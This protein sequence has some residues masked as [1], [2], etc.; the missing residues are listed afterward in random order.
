MKSK[1][2]Q[3]LK[4]DPPGNKT[5]QEEEEPYLSSLD[6][7]QNM[8]DLESLLKS[9][10]YQK[11]LHD[12]INEMMH[13]GMSESE[14]VSK[15]SQSLD[16]VHEDRMEK[17]S[18]RDGE[19]VILNPEV[20]KRNYQEGV[21]EEAKKMERIQEIVE[22][23]TQNAELVKETQERARILKI[24]EDNAQEFSEKFAKSAQKSIQSISQ[25]IEEARKEFREL[26]ERSPERMITNEK[27]VD[28]L[29]EQRNVQEVIRNFPED[30]D[31]IRSTIEE[32]TR[33]KG[34]GRDY[35]A[36]VQ[37]EEEDSEGR[38]Y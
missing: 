3:I 21:R 14:I 26:V 28:W 4:H 22:Q 36:L 10:G 16:I 31:A 29:M 2:N 35:Y 20:V 25:K 24:V 1:W 32:I 6:S 17:E 30:V 37:G 38:G 19:E 7:E 13:H 27:E 23:G 33:A 15:L 18:T 12:H 34:E 11:K 8:P 5:K 9:P